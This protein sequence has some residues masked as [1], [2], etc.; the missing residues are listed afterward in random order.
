MVL[1]DSFNQNTATN[2]PQKELGDEC[3][4]VDTYVKDLGSM[5]GYVNRSQAVKRRESI[6][7]TMELV[8][9]IPAF[10]QRIKDNEDNVE[11][12]AML[13]IR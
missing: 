9:N 6:A 13:G 11:F 8:P 3:W 7:K 12:R 10:Q 4:Y 5:F 2:T 1:D